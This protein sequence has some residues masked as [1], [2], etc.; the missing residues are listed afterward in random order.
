MHSRSWGEKPEGKRPVK[1]PRCGWEDN[2][3]MGIRE[4]GSGGRD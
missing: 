3:K 4:I 2:V 1:R